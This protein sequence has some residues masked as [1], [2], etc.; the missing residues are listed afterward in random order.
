MLIIMND[1]EV[2]GLS[3]NLFLIVAART[4]VTADISL[5]RA[6]HVAGTLKL[7]QRSPRDNHTLRHLDVQTRIQ[8]FSV[9]SLQEGVLEFEVF[10]TSTRMSRVNIPATR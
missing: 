2:A 7:Q 10:T 3:C 1:G 4:I 6:Q 8:P 9:Q 5:M